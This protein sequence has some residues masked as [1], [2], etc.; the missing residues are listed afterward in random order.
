VDFP[1]ILLILSKQPP[2][3]AL[4]RTFRFFNTLATSYLERLS[5][6]FQLYVVGIVASSVDAKCG[7]MRWICDNVP[8]LQ[9][10]ARFV[11]DR[12]ARTRTGAKRPIVVDGLLALSSRGGPT[13]GHILQSYAL[14]SL[15]G[16]KFYFF[17]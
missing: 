12:G 5:F 6:N 13:F 11:Y 16:V 14:S 4:W 15:I 9:A 17:S 3:S 2:A 7:K 10:E 1:E 8:T